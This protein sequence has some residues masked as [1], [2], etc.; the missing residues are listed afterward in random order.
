[1]NGFTFAK[2]YIKT[3]KSGKTREAIRPGSIYTDNKN[4]VYMYG[5]DRIPRKLKKQV[6]R[7]AKPRNLMISVFIKP[8]EVQLR[9]PAFMWLECFKTIL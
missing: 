8:N 1:M 5:F 3:Y 7:Y 6:K 2:A 9:D 4:F